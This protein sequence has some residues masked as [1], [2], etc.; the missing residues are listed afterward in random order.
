MKIYKCSFTG[1]EVLSDA[2]DQLPPFGKDELCSVAFEVI[3]RMITLGGEDYGI[4]DNDE[5]EG[6]GGA[7]LEQV[8]D[9]TNNF[10]LNTVPM[11]KKEFQAY[12]RTYMGF[13]KEKVPAEKL[14]E[15]QKGMMTLIKEILGSFDE[16]EVMFSEEAIDAVHESKTIPV[17]CI[18]R[19]DGNPHFIYLSSGL[20]E[21]KF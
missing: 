13:V 9:I 12:I 3:G 8:V 1:A 15:W 21:E 19:D 10:H 16:F 14:A 7:E 17:F 6:G 20:D 5:E 11:T 2:Y 4:E 18:W